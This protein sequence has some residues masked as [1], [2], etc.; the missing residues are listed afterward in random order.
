MNTNN[1][2]GFTCLRYDKTLIWK[3]FRSASL[4]PALN[5]SLYNKSNI[6]LTA[7]L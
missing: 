6:G 7:V 4:R 3:Q 2:E 1:S 5:S